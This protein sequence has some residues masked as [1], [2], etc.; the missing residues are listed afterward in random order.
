M[1]ICRTK[2]FFIHSDITLNKENTWKG[3]KS[4]KYSFILA[5]LIILYINSA[6]YRGICD[7]KD[8]AYLIPIA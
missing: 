8:M 2:L 1:D 6:A 5:V 3:N 7:I 4:V